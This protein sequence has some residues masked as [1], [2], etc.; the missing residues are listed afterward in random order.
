MADVQYWRDSIISEIEQ[1]R[2]LVSSIPNKSD[3]LDRTT[4]IDQAEKKIRSAK[5]NCKSLKVEIR[6]IADPEEAS[7]YRKELASYEQTLSQL[8]SEVQGLKS[9][10]SK[11]RLFLGA[12]TASDGYGSPEQ[13]DPVSAGD[14]LLDGADHLQDKTQAA[15]TN[16]NRMTQE[17]KQTGMMTLEELERQ[18]NQINNVDENVM[19]L[20][21][22]LNRADTLIKAFG[23]RMAT[24]KLIQA[25]ACINILLIVGVVVWSIVKG[26]LPGPDQ[27]T[28]PESPIA[29]GSGQS[30]SNR[31]LRGFMQ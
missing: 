27:E 13:A 21:D 28:P 17:A 11:N 6:I 7:R 8:T 26:G 30:A 4:T 15:L 5:G 3:D 18:R 14:A 16:I 23:K 10:E 12:N 1:I 19:R 31:L 22:N 2:A 25:F 29:G 24:D 9:E 20:E